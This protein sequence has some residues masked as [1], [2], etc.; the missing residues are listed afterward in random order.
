M[1]C[2][3]RSLPLLQPVEI[4]LPHWPA[5]GPALALLAGRPGRGA[6]TDG[7]RLPADGRSQLAVAVEFRRDCRRA[8][9]ACPLE[10]RRRYLLPILYTV[11]SLARATPCFHHCLVSLVLFGQISTIA[12]GA[13][14]ARQRSIARF[15]WP[16]SP[17]GGNTTCR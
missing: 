3:P 16:S 11:A 14:I 2:V 10:R 12:S 13:K 17:P 9:A 7:D 6:R 4:Q 15:R 1:E 8:C 5:Q